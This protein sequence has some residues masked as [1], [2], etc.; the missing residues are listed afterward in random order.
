MIRLS[1]RPL[2]LDHDYIRDASGNIIAKLYHHDEESE[3]ERKRSFRNGLLLSK[4]PEL[5]AALRA[6]TESMDNWVELQD[7]EDA[8]DCDDKALSTAHDLINKL[9]K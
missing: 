8:R 3:T 1:P 2:K 6:T 9:E 5:L 4:A 7:D